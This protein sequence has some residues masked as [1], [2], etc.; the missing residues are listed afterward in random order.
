MQFPLSVTFTKCNSHRIKMRYSVELRERGH[1][2]GYGF[3]SFV[4]NV[5]T[6]A[7]KVPKNMN[8]KYGQ[9]LA[10]TA[11]KSATDAIKTASKRAIQKTAEATGD[12][13]GNKIADKITSTSTEFHSKKPLKKPRDEESS[14][15]EVN[16]EI[17]K[18]RYISPN[19]RQLTI[20]ELRLI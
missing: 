13:V 2:K 8:N 15:T 16:K 20:D 4:K 9:K 5:G 7:T 3:L 6:H 14:S 10:D 19:E 1:V 12:L 11:K 17:R 18:E